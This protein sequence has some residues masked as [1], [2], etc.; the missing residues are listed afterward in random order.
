MNVTNT[1]IDGPRTEFASAWLAGNRDFH[2]IPGSATVFHLEGDDFGVM[3]EVVELALCGDGVEGTAT[4]PVVPGSVVS[5]GFEAPGHP[6]RRGEI[7]GCVRCEDGW[8]IG[9]AF[10]AQAAA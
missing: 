3:H 8:K 5:L 10:D 2:S 1:L 4:K 9:I 6:A 7:V